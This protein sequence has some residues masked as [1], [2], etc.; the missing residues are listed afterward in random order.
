ME[1]ADIEVL[2]PPVAV[3]VSA[4]ATGERAFA[5]VIVSLCVHVV[6][7]SNFVIFFESFWMD[8]GDFREASLAR[9]RLFSSGQNFR[10]RPCA[11]RS[12]PVILTLEEI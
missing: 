7:R 10:A 9:Y 12:G 2:W 5:R 3:P 6:L 11:S 8:R 1:H 4:G